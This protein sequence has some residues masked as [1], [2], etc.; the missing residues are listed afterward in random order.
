MKVLNVMSLDFTYLAAIG[1]YEGAIIERNWNGAS[2]LTLKI[3][4]ATPNA[5][6]LVQDRILWFDKEYH[7][8][9]IIE[10]VVEKLENNIKLLEITALSLHSLIRDYITI[11][12]TGYDE[13]SVSDNR[14]G[15]V[16]AY[17]NLNC[18][19]PADSSRVQYPLILGTDNNYGTATVCSTRLKNLA[20]EITKV[21]SPEFLGWRVDIDLVATKFVFNVLKGVNRTIGQA[22]NPR[23]IFGTKY[24]NMSRYEK[25]QDSLSAK[26]VA[27]VGGQGEGKDRVIQKVS[28]A[29]GRKKE[30]FIDARDKA[31]VGELT[32]QGT[33]ALSENVPVTNFTFETLDRQFVFGQDWDLGDFVT[34]V[35]EDGTYDDRQ[36]IKVTEYIEKGN[37]RITPE[38]GSGEVT[39]GGKITSISARLAV[40]ETFEPPEP[41]IPSFTGMI[42]AS[43]TLI[44]GFL[45]CDGQAVSR[46]TYATLFNVLGVYFGTGDGSTTFNL[47]NLKGKTIFGQD[48]TQP[49]FDVIGET[50]GTKV[51]TTSASANTHNDYSSGTL[52][53]A[54]PSHTHTVGILPPYMALK[55]LIKY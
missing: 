38:F 25:T 21:L 15:V 23:T 19:N 14:E 46:T 13:H 45:E 11:P 52:D 51:G 32:E 7:N 31:T 35:Q 42:I 47:P 43:A 39:I 48:T 24:G 2:Y 9:F 12:P 30:V 20:D 4:K 6:T 50:G 22:V 53:G 55:Y 29:V 10:R 49:E 36:V 3:N 16:R 33:Q 5:D 41:V 40:L 27:Y 37:R 1:G 44:D 26:N 54:S 28:S 17:V 34:I 18:I 8:G